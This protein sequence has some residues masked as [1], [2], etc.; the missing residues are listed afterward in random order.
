[1]RCASLF[2]LVTVCV[3]AMNCR[4][5]HQLCATNEMTHAETF[6][7]DVALQRSHLLQASATYDH[8]TL[9]LSMRGGAPI[10]VHYRV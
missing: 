6:L 3:L 2:G 7:N 5:N 4:E 9:T 10:E 1:M 8:L